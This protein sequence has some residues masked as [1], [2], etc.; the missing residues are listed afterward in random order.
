[1]I[2]LS[3]RIHNKCNKQMTS[4]KINSQESEDPST[5]EV[6]NVADGTF[7]AFLELMGNSWS[8]LNKSLICH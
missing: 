7:V 8:Y 5:E 2:I 3:L 1:M 4:I 6:L